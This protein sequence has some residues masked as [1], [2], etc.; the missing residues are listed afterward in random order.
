MKSC[1]AL[2]L[3]LRIVCT[4]VC[5]MCQSSRIVVSISGSVLRIQDVVCPW[6]KRVVFSLA[7]HKAHLVLKRSME[8]VVLAYSSRENLPSCR[9]ER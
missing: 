2:I 8:A 9:V 6:T 7:S 4:I 3:L 5:T 1:L